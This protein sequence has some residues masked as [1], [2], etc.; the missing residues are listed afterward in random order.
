MLYIN[1]KENGKV[2]TLDCFETYKEAREMLKEYK[3]S[4][5]Y[6]NVA[7]I[8]NRS[9]RDWLKRWEDYQ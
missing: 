9:T 5:N 3:L 1:I 8:S 6:Y 4:S 2:E 7:Y